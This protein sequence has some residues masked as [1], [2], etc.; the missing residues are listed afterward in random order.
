MVTVQN[1]APTGSN[2]DIQNVNLLG[3]PTWRVTGNVQDAPV[4]GDPLTA[5]IDWGDGTPHTVLS[6]VLT[7]NAEHTY[8]PTGQTHTV[9]VTVRDDDTGV[10]SWY[11]SFE[12]YRLD[13]DNAI[14]DPFEHLAPG[15]YLSVNDDDDNANSIAD[16]YDAGPASQENDLVPFYLNFTPAYRPEVNN[17]VGWYVVLDAPEGHLVWENADKTNPVIFGT[18]DAGAGTKLWVV[19]AHIIPSTLYLEGVG[20]GTTGLSLRLMEPIGPTTVDVDS[21]VFT[22]VATLIDLDASTIEHNQATG[23]L[24]DLIEETEGAWVP[25]NVDDD[26]YDA[27]NTSD[28][29]QNGAWPFS[30]ETD[31][32][33]VLIRKIDPLILGGNFTLTIPGNL[34]VW[35]KREGVDA[36][37]AVNATT[38]LDATKDWTLY[39]EGFELGTSLLRVNWSNPERS[40]P[41]ADRVKI[42]VFPWNGPINV[43][44]HSRYLYR[45]WGQVGAGNSRWISAENGTLLN[46]ETNNPNPDFTEHVSEFYWDGGPAIGKASFKAAPSYIWD[47]EV[48]IVQVEVEP[49]SITYGNPAEQH[50][51]YDN[52]ISSY[53][54]IALNGAMDAVT[55]V[56]RIEPPSRGGV[57]RGAK[58]IEMGFIQNLIA[59]AMHGDYLF[60]ASDSNDD[61][62]R[63]HVIVDGNWYVDSLPSSALP[64]YDSIG[65]SA[66]GAGMFAP[67]SDVIIAGS[68]IPIFHVSDRPA[69]PG[70]DELVTQGNFGDDAVDG[71]VILV[72]F[73]LYFAVR[74]KDNRNE[75]DTRYIQRAAAAWQFDGTGTVTA[76]AQW[77]D[78]DWNNGAALDTLGVHENNTGDAVFN[79]VTSGLL[80][81]V[82]QGPNANDVLRT[83][84]F[85]EVPPS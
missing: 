57:L 83:M 7:V 31:L 63:Q 12:N 15:E 11:E 36:V 77:S 60:L 73:N 35:M 33:P 65:E 53:G 42:T 72:D 26:D 59:T 3:G 46:S 22:A 20:G 9:T 32:L 4:W 69:V 78:F 56:Q 6:N 18:T 49:G 16:M 39:V 50:F 44:G 27:S 2:F 5:T 19:G 54:G 23:F 64:W 67:T 21:I 14:A 80:V 84:Q 47:W 70:T 37:D 25:T 28:R 79:I 34:R 13:I 29:L 24:D 40:I 62:R 17:Y 61:I 82:V 52:V 58:F 51:L 43:P 75:A 8:L 1:I 38:L 74:T 76:N 68:A 30:T 66:G 71:F 45:A 55:T 85:I 41:N 48:N 81:P 10:W